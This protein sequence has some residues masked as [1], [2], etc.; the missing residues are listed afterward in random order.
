MNLSKKL[1]KQLKDDSSF[2]E[3]Q[4]YILEVISDLDS[5]VGFDTKDDNEMLG[6]KLRAR[7]IAKEKLY[8]ILKPFID[9]S[10]KREPTKEEKEKA[11]DKF[12]L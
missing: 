7:I 5:V 11:K 2:Q 6:E 4:E 9:F 3:F 8:Q 1:I 12:G 10:E